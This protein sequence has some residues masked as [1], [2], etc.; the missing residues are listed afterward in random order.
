MKIRI[1]M[2]EQL[3]PDVLKITTK[4]TNNSTQIA[5]KFI[6]QALSL[7]FSKDNR[8]EDMADNKVPKEKYKT[9]SLCSSSVVLWKTNL[10]KI[11]IAS[12]IQFKLFDS[13]KT[14]FMHK[15]V[16]VQHKLPFPT[17][18]MLIQTHRLT[19]HYCL[20]QYRTK[21]WKQAHTNKATS[22]HISNS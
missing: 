18:A 13:K 17:K 16:C 4:Q 12:V 22:R 9:T 7:K 20:V 15:V 14:K 1:T 21:Y 6:C 3:A 5:V 11:W 19:E 10:H 2:I 8:N